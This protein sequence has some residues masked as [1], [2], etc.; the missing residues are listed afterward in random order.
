[1]RAAFERLRATGPS[2]LEVS[3][4]VAE[5][6]NI[7]AKANKNFMPRTPKYVQFKMIFSR[8]RVM[9]ELSKRSS[10]MKFSLLAAAVVFS[11]SAL[12]GPD[13]AKLKITSKGSGLG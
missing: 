8:A 12:A 13:E 11:S 3:I 4:A 5:S 2:A 7:I 9:P 1:M 10:V 6:D